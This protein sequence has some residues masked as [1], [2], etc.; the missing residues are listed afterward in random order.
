MQFQPA[1]MH[2]HANT[3]PVDERSGTFASRFTIHP[4]KRHIHLSSVP[5][6]PAN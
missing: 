1:H 6:N 4:N 5:F 3:L 2:T